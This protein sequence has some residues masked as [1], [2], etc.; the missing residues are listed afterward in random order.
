[1]FIKA[2]LAVLMLSPAIAI[3]AGLPQGFVPPAGIPENCMAPMAHVEEMENIPAI[4]NLGPGAAKIVSIKTPF[5]LKAN[6]IGK[7]AY[8]LM[9]PITVTWSNGRVDYGYTFLIWNGDY[10][11]IMVDYK[12]PG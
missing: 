4:L 5:N 9:C 7:D 6:L 1:M 8:R 2:A 3:A 10:G 11:Q 12:S